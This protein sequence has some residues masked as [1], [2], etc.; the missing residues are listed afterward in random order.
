[1]QSH[2]SWVIDRYFL[3]AR[4]VLSTVTGRTGANGSF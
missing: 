4:V 3:L 1:M 2:S